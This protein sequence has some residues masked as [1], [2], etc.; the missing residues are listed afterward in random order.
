VPRACA[1]PVQGMSQQARDGASREELEA[2][3]EFAL[4]IW[5]RS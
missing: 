4:S 1:P 5:P 3:A 2:V